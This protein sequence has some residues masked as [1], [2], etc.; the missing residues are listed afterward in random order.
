MRKPNYSLM[1]TNIYFIVGVSIVVGLCFNKNIQLPPKHF[2]DSPSVLLDNS[3]LQNKDP[4]RDEKLELVG[5]Y[6][7]STSY[8]KASH[9]II[10]YKQ[11]GVLTGLWSQ[12][13]SDEKEGYPYGAY[14]LENVQFGTDGS[15]KFNV[16]WD[17]YFRGEGRVRKHHYFTGQLVNDVI[18]GEFT[19]DWSALTPPSIKAVKKTQ[20]DLKQNE[21]D[22]VL[23]RQRK[24]SEYVADLDRVLKCQEER[25]KSPGDPIRV[26]GFWSKV[27][28]N[29]EHE[30][31]Y[32]VVLF[33]VGDVYRG[34]IEDYSGLVGDGGIRYIMDDIHYDKGA[35]QLDFKDQAQYGSTQYKALL[36]K[37][38]LL[39]KDFN[40]KKISLL[41]SV[42]T[43]PVD[44]VWNQYQE[45]VIECK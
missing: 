27:D 31:G 9:E 36:R 21:N 16:L 20:L 42:K 28:S 12:Y 25:Q 38:R 39:L 6:I 41:H 45:L 8:L 17:M 26:I 24:A 3:F 22:Y 35:G 13:F 4:I 23:V 14:P 40:G 1:K 15:L 7:D 43:P 33:T 32:D 19:S 11:G 29:G 10:L 30:W 34:W 5:I 18:Q 44:Q 2:P 37:K